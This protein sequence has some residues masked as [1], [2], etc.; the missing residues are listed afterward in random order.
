MP[1]PVA[2]RGVEKRQTVDRQVTIQVI[3]GVQDERDSNQ[4]DPGSGE[5]EDKP[6]DWLLAYWM[7]RY[8]GILTAAQ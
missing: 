5:R 6:T 2:A 1:P 8:Y 7:G 4:D 3:L